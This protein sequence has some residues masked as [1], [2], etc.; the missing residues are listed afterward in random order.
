VD[1]WSLG[2]V[3]FYMAVGRMPFAVP[4]DST[5]DPS[6]RRRMLFEL[7]KRGAVEQ[8]VKQMAHFSPEFRDLVQVIGWG[9]AS[10]AE[11]VHSG[12]NPRG[13]EA[14]QGSSWAHTT[15]LNGGQTRPVG[16]VVESRGRGSP[17]G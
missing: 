13:R 9:A 10:A 14:L 6:D 12:Y 4:R 1:L 8:H 7:I 16:G 15:P 17:S 11:L 3:L 2:V 5:P